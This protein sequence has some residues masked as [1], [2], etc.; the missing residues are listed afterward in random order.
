ME[1]EFDKYDLD[2]LVDQLELLKAVYSD[3]NNLT[4]DRL[5]KMKKIFGIYDFDHSGGIDR[6]E[7]KALVQKC[8]PQLGYNAKPADA[9]CYKVFKE[10]DQDNSG[11]VSFDEFSK[12]CL[13]IM[14]KVYA[15][16]LEAYLHAE[17][18]RLF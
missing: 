2:F 18:L 11:S 13:A 17:G 15:G 3:D 4:K 9:E 6:E 8:Y 1:Q 10:M 16:P 7:C 5:L 12:Y 14:R